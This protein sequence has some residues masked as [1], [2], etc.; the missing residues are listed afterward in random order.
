MWFNPFEGEVYEI[1]KKD[2]YAR[3]YFLGLA[4]AHSELAANKSTPEY[5]TDRVKVSGAGVEH[6][7]V[8]IGWTSNI[9][10]EDCYGYGFGVL[11]W[12]RSAF[13]VRGE[14]AAALKPIGNWRAGPR[15]GFG[16]R[17][18]T[19]DR[20]GIGTEVLMDWLVAGERASADEYD[21]LDSEGGLFLGTVGVTYEL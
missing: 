3:R 16:L 11:S 12:L 7:T 10:F 9:F 21:S 15:L 2:H 20:F 6:L 14:G 8:E 5:V 18:G 19:S 13:R 1:S 4:Y 17:I